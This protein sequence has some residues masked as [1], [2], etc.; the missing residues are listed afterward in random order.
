MKEGIKQTEVGAIPKDWEVK[1]ISEIITEISMGPF[2]SDI[3]VSNFTDRGVPVLNGYNISG[4]KLKNRHSNFV[5]RAKAKDLKKALAKRGDIV[6]THRGTLGQIAYIPHDSVYEEYVISQ[7]QFRFTL[8]SD[9]ALPEFVVYFFHSNNGQNIIS[10]TKGHT[11]VP[12]IAQATTTFRK[13]SIPLPPLSEQK[14]IAN[15][16]GDADGWI[17]SL[18]ALLEK[19]RL[20]KQ[21]VMQE[22]LQP[23]EDWNVKKLGELAKFFKGKGLPK[24]SI[25]EYGNYSCIHYGELFTDYREIIS[26]VF[27]KTFGDE[28]AF[29][30]MPNDILMPTSDVT[31]RGLATASCIQE[32]GIILGGDILVIRFTDEIDGRFF[33]YYITNNKDEVLKLVSGSTVYHL[34]GSEMA[35][36]VFSYPNSLFEQSRIVSILSD[37]DTEISAVEQ[38]LFKARQIKQGMMQQLLTGKIRLVKPA[39][40]KDVKTSKRVTA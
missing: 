15:A 11:G 39:V 8:N 19:K 27:S 6:V 37:L 25:S 13:I 1:T 40:A 17:E 30:S 36:L 33:A 24:S 12:A 21:G 18:E 26:K 3:K 32:G 28:N 31:P 16:L 4:I 22:L 9:K 10:E 20:I 35:N 7:S 2:G 23:K 5:T 34:Y 38:K 29:Y 14:A